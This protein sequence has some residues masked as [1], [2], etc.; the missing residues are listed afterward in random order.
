MTIISE[1]KIY[2]SIRFNGK[3]EYSQIQNIVMVVC[4]WLCNINVGNKA[5]KIPIAKTLLM[6][7]MDIE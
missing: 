7:I 1:M 4:R 3:G 6:D 2:V 5:L